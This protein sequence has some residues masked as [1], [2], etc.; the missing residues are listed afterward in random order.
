MNRTLRL[1]VTFVAIAL[2]SP[3]AA[4]AYGPHGYYRGGIW[5]DPWWVAPSPY[6][7][8]PRVIVERPATEYYVQP[9]PQQPEEPAYWYY[10]RR[11]EGYYPYIKQCP[12][13][14]MKVVPTPPSQRQ[15]K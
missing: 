14:W 7:S 12:D 8:A 1:L 13:G 11:P 10:C 5:I 9:A 15:E 4:D 3:L 2:L 6:Y